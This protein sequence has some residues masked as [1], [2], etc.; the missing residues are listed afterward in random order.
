MKPFDYVEPETIEEAIDWLGRGPGKSRV[1]AGGTDLLVRLKRRQWIA[2]RVVSIRRIGDLRG[3]TRDDRGIWIGALTTIEELRDVPY[4]RDVA[5]SMASAQIRN[6]A[7]VGGNLCN[8]SPAADLGPPLLVLGA[9]LVAAGPEG[10]RAIP[11]SEFFLGPGK[12]AL[13][14]DEILT[15][16]RVPGIPGRAAFLKFGPIAVVSVAAATGRVA[17]GA[18]APT[19]ILVP[20]DPEAAAA[21]CSPI[22]DPRASAEYRRHLVRV[23]TRRALEKV[24]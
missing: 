24:S 9:T 5:F 23:L 13:R 12:S 8:A 20:A 22:D 3:V 16:V 7:T 4:L 10:E 17:L 6:L 15:G 11:M 2:D 1:L 19:P 14:H 21:A 18:V